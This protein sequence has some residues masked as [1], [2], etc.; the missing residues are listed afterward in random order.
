MEAQKLSFFG[1]RHKKILPP[2]NPQR[3]IEKIEIPLDLSLL[4]SA[5]NVLMGMIH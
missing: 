5:Y 3:K 2:L 4:M 1:L